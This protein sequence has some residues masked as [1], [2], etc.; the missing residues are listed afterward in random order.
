MT[1]LERDGVL[2]SSVDRDDRRSLI[3]IL[4]PRGRVVLEKAIDLNIKSLRAAF[5]ALSVDEL[6]TLTSLSQRLR[7]S[8]LAV[9]E[10][11]GPKR[12]GGIAKGDLE[13]KAQRRHGGRVHRA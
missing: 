4:I 7:Q 12:K 6:E 9:R 5:A 11:P 3:A 8:F 10:D 13:E 2:K 1:A